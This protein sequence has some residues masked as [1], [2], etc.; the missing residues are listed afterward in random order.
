MK[1]FYHRPA[2][3]LPV[4]VIA[5]FAG[6]SLWFAGNAVLPDLQEFLS[7]PSGSL[8]SITSAVQLGFIFGTLTFATLTIADRFSP[9]KVFF[10][11]AIAGAI[12]NLAPVVF[13]SYIPILGFRFATGFFLA[14]IYPVGMKIASDWHEKGLGKALGY[15]VGALVLG[16]AFPHLIS[17]L[18]GGLPWKYILIVTSIVAA[19]GGAIILIFVSDGPFR[20]SGARFNSHAI[21]K[22]FK[23]VS[24]KRAAFGYFGHM[25][26][27]YA[28][29]AFVPF[30]IL[31]HNKI[32]NN[33]LSSPA[34]SF[35]IIGSGSLSCALGGHISLYQGSKKVA[36]VMIFYKPNYFLC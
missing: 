22:L 27:L 11:C 17:D 12:L 34:W 19:L 32:T 16:T 26:E 30:I 10:F 2:Y 35:V 28:F 25:W 7:L 4:I 36:S 1:E 18:T 13:K 33:S 8:G 6:T 9:S 3:I 15:L 14:G 24:F 23:N 5:Q 21:L 31:H 20:K 29:W